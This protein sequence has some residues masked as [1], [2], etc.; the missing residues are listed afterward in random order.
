VAEFRIFSCYSRWTKVATGLLRVNPCVSHYLALLAAKHI[1]LLVT[2]TYETI[3]YSEVK[4]Y[5]GNPIVYFLIVLERGFIS[6]EL[7]GVY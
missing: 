5:P 1:F 2:K 6:A 4:V 7:T 3:I